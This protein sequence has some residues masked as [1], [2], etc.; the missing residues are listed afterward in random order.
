MNFFIVPGP[1]SENYS[2]K[3]VSHGSV[4][5]VWYDSPALKLQR[6]MYVYTPAGYDT[7]KQK[8]PVLYLLHGAGGDEDARN[9]VGRGSVIMDNL[10]AS[11]KAKPMLVVMTNGNAY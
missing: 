9:N 11:C 2:L 8:Y 1:L 5:I 6:R 10:L 4:N 7:G 3:D